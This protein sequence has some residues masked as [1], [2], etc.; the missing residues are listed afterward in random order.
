MNAERGSAC[1]GP[2]HISSRLTVHWSSNWLCR[3]AATWNVIRLNLMASPKLPVHS[4]SS[5][6][7]DASC[8]SRVAGVM[9]LIRSTLGR[10]LKLVAT[11]SARG[12][13]LPDSFA[14]FSNHWQLHEIAEPIKVSAIRANSCQHSLRWP[15]STRGSVTIAGSKNAIS[16][17]RT[18]RLRPVPIQFR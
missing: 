4:H 1:L 18:V 3:A 13:Y 15:K 9:W 11:L 6:D 2:I 5:S 14:R 12:V 7:T 17:R 16:R 8:G 10:P